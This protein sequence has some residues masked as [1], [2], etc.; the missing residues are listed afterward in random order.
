MARYDVGRGIDEV[1]CL[2]QHRQRAGVVAGSQLILDVDD[3]L[4]ELQLV[5]FGTLELAGESRDFVRRLSGL[6]FFI[7]QV[8]FESP[9]VLFPPSHLREER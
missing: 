9:D 5:G 1:Q 3:P 7:V 4:P 6:G 8:R 2:V